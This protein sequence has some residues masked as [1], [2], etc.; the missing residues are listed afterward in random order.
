[1]TIKNITKSKQE[2]KKDQGNKLSKPVILKKS[3]ESID[4]FENDFEPTIPN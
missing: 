2:L 1:M 3:S 4:P